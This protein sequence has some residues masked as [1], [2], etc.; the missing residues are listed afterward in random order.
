VL[1]PITIETKRGVFKVISNDADVVETLSW[2]KAGDRLHVR[3][4]PN[5]H[6]LILAPEVRK[7]HATKGGGY[8]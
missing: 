4:R 1:L 2:R 7:T 3:G 5:G 6:N 8:C